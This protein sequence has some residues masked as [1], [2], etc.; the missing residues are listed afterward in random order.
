MT[1]RPT[2]AVLPP[3]LRAR[4]GLV[5]ALAALVV[6]ALA[7]RYAG[8]SRPGR[9]DRW[10]VPPTADSV[11]PPL[12]YV[13]HSLDFLGEPTGSVMVVVAAVTGCL[14]LR[15]PRA[16]VLLVAG[17]GLAV[18]TATLLKHLVGRTIHGADNLSYPSGHTAFLTA[19]AFVAGLL[20]TDRLGLGG[21]AGTSLV[22]AVTLVAGAAM[23]WAQVALGAHYSTDALGGWCTALAVMP[24]TAWLVDT[25]ADRWVDRS[26]GAGRRERR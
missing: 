17:A 9:V 11:R 19:L 21:T 20:A 2:T 13:A 26:A 18:G 16:A 15:R 12:R 25:A 1:G 24:V 7:V 5:A 4:L 22:L 10:I 6:A 8:D 3:S 14:L 23:G